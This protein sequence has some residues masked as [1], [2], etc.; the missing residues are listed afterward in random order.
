MVSNEYV[1]KQHSLIKYGKEIIISMKKLIG[2]RTTK[3]TKEARAKKIYDALTIEQKNDLYM[4]LGKIACGEIKNFY[5][6]KV[7]KEMI[8]DFGHNQRAV[9]TY[10]CRKQGQL[11]IFENMEELVLIE[12]K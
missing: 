11:N 6:T 12:E 9:L 5:S 4:L 8:K 3:V 1:F 7:Y 10:I 2:K